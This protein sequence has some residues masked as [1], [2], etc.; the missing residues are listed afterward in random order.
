[1]PETVDARTMPE[2][3]GEVSVRDIARWAARWW[4]LVLCGCVAGGLLGLIW[5]LASDERFT[6]RLDMTI[7]ESP[8]GPASFVTEV[9]TNL[10]R[11]HVGTSVSVEFDQ[12]RNRLSLVERGVPAEA[13]AARKASM[14]GAAA[15]L[16]D[17][18]D[19]MASREYARMQ[20]RLLTTESSADAYA[21]LSRFRL[22]V[23]ALQ[24]GLL[25][26]VVVVSES[27]RRH[28]PALA[29]LLGLGALAGAG[30]AAAAAL[31][32]DAL[33]RR[34]GGSGR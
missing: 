33:G 22:H 13:V 4:W 6:V 9:S 14:H 23:S 5:H 10:L 7:T 18:L 32:V 3:D 16:D 31:A 29:A 21:S 2:P 1:M 34:R 20:D 24:D 28:G 27:V 19:G 26:S 12:R 25:E 11:R 30:L 15:A 8:V 17:F